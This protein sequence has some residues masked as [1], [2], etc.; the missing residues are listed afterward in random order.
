[1]LLKKDIS[2]IEIIFVKRNK[3]TIFLSGFMVLTM[4]FIEPKIISSLK[5]ILILF[6]A[7]IYYFSSRFFG[8]NNKDIMGISWAASVPLVVYAASISVNN[9]D[10]SDFDK[11]INCVA[12]LSLYFFFI[13]GFYWFLSLKKRVFFNHNDIHNG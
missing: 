2:I 4:I 5:I 7:L 11:N 3:L 9:L 6:A 13:A 8:K 10:W 1:M 12:Y